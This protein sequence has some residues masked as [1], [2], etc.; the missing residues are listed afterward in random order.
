M[1]SA[2]ISLTYI[3]L[4]S[5]PT[6]IPSVVFAVIGY[7]LGNASFPTYLSFTNNEASPESLPVF[8]YFT[9]ITNSPKGKGSFTSI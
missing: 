9:F 5:L 3:S 8:I 2:F 7:T 1:S 6:D 4:K